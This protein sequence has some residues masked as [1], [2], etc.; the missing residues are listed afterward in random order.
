MSVLY[1]RGLDKAHVSR[2]IKWMVVLDAGAT[3]TDH[4]WQM[5]MYRALMNN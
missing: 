4:D 1:H 3:R 5:L 2:V